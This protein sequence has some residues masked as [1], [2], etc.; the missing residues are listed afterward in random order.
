[1]NK[2]CDTLRADLS[3]Y[4]D[5]ELGAEDRQ[6][7]EAHI[8][9]CAECR[10]VLDEWR[11]VGSAL[12]AL[13][14]VP[15]AAGSLPERVLALVRRG[16]PARETVLPWFALPALRWAAVLAAVVCGVVAAWL[17]LPFGPRG[18]TDVAGELG[19]PEA[20]SEAPAAVRPP[21]APPARRSEGAFR[22]EVAELAEAAYPAEPTS[23]DALAYGAEVDFENGLARKGMDRLGHDR[24]DGAE[25]VESLGR[26]AGTARERLPEERNEDVPFFRAERAP[27]TDDL[28]AKL[29][30]DYAG[31]DL[32]RSFEPAAPARE[33]AADGATAV[34]EVSNGLLAGRLTAN[35]GLSDHLGDESMR[36]QGKGGL[37]SS[38]RPD[39]APAR[40]QVIDA[41]D[42][43]T[44]SMAQQRAEVREGAV[45]R[46]VETRAGQVTTQ[47][48]TDLG[49]EMAA[50][51]QAYHPVTQPAA[52]EAVG[53]RR[54]FGAAH[55][56]DDVQARRVG[57]L[58]FVA[59][60]A[61]WAVNY[62]ETVARELDGE[63][64][65]G[66][67]DACPSESEA[68]FQVVFSASNVERF[69]HA[70]EANNVR[71]VDW[72][73]PED[74]VAED[75][76][77]DGFLPGGEPTGLRAKGGLAAGAAMTQ[78]FGAGDAVAGLSG[79]RPGGAYF[80]YDASGGPAL[81][82]YC[83][84]IEGVGDPAP[85]AASID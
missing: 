68:A 84:E 2:A 44:G 31:I 33:L 81:R 7:I 74:P 78:E 4:L 42:L 62:S 16:E 45:L 73:S 17:A 85:G 48:P 55:F 60:D 56:Y 54:Q 49:Y 23:R 61:D 1:M 69:V 6:R 12:A 47:P 9:G 38:A 34:E 71:V 59:I 46:G 40:Q 21:V 26:L 22:D 52:P 72:E 80:A 14:A 79:G 82:T 19:P 37:A 13:C 63:I 29:D 65:P 10:R 30:V 8:E 67:T 39:A 24:D 77:A 57:H 43:K 75:L 50:D 51:R 5:G 11:R 70:L 3:A 64:L 18:G 36:I 15:S 27:A 28:D 58:R 53:A 76:W 83:V 25:S 35:L 66:A 20:I 32:P 41:S